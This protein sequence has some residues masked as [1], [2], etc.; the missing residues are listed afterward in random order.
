M[1]SQP[2]G[3]PISQ[4][5]LDGLLQANASGALFSD[6]RIYRYLLWRTW[7]QSGP[8]LL[9]VGLNPST[10]DENI[11]DPTIRRCIGFAREHS[12]RGVLV[13][14]LF[15]FRATKPR[16]LFAAPEPVGPDTDEWLGA[17]HRLATHTVACWG[18]HGKFRGRSN[19]AI[20]MLDQLLC[21]GTTKAGEPRH[22]LYLKGDTRMRSLASSARDA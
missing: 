1:T 13:S 8:L 19:D 5:R 14:N 22:P 21:L 9:F 17:A 10:A 15:A 3:S 6:D 7:Q 18:V 16:D 2:Q 20:A 12:A 4:A 11:N